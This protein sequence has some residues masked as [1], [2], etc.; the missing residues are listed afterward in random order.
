MI[1]PAAIGL[2]V[3]GAAFLF[4][5]AAFSSYG[6]S[7]L[8]L[9]MGGA[10]GYLLAPTLAGVLGLTG[11]VATGGAVVVGAIAGVLLGYAL[12]SLAVGAIAFVVGTYVGLSVVAGLLVDGGALVEIP[13]AI[14]FGIVLALLGTVMTKTMMVLLTAFVGAALASRTITLEGLNTAAADVTPDPLL[15]DVTAPLF[16][17]LFVLGVLSQFGLFKLGYVTRLLRILPGGRPLRNRTEQD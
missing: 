5:G 7:A 11:T 14:A 16:V 15:F 10:T 12:L 6:V 1:E 17:G 3:I 4:F 9:L 2:V 8:G 13:V